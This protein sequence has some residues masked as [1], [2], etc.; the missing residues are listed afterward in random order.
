ML[1]GSPDRERR[2]IER[3]KQGAL[4]R[5]IAEEFGLTV[6]AVAQ[7]FNARGM[8]RHN[9]RWWKITPELERRVVE[10][11]LDG[12]TYREIREITGV[13]GRTAWSI[14]KRAGLVFR[15]ADRRKSGLTAPR[16]RE[17]EPVFPPEDDF[18]LRPAERARLEEVRRKRVEEWRAKYGDAD[19][20]LCSEDGSGDSDL[21]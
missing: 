11:R 12:K 2:M 20:G 1:H 9:R 17:T 15:R 5:E 18:E 8:R 19:D 14:M 4:L 10:L 6:G 13:D 3:W 21:D 16:V 7:W